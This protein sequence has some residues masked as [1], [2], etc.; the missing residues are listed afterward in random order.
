MKRGAVI[1]RRIVEGFLR[2]EVNAVAGPVIK[3]VVPL[4]VCDQGTRIGE[5][6]FAALYGFERS[7]ILAGED[8]DAIDLLGVKD[9]IHAMNHAA[10]VLFYSRFIGNL[11]VAG[12]LILRRG[13]H[14][15]E[16]DMRTF[17]AFTHL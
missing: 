1:T 11:V 4:I 15:P 17:L 12:T 10:V 16:F 9:R 5:K 6:A 2:W 13:F 3:G 8:R 14:L 7:S